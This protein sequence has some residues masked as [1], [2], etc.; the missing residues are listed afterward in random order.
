MRSAF[1]E[2]ASSSFGCTSS[3]TAIWSIKAPVPPA[4]EPFIRSSS[5]PVRNTIFASSPPNSMTTSAFGTKVPTH[6]LVAKTSC[7]KSTPL[8]F[9]TPR[10]AEPVIATQIFASPI[11]CLAS[12]SISQAFSRTFEKCRSYFRY[13]ISRRPVAS[14]TP[15]A[16]SFT[17]VEPISIPKYTFI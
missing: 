17:V 16:T 2:S 12:R 1:S 7:T 15:A 11:T 6:F 8:A 14:F 10:P 5:C 3:N 13:K 9:A 4:Q